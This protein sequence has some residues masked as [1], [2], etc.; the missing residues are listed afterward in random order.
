MSIGEH[1]SGSVGF[2]IKLDTLRSGFVPGQELCWVHARAGVVRSQPEQQPQQ[3]QPPQPSQQSQQTQPSQQEQQSQQPQQPAVVVTMQPLKLSGSDIFYT[4]SDMRT[5]DR[6]RTWQGP[7]EQQSLARRTLEEGIEVAISDFTPGWHQATGKLLGTG[8]TV[9]YRGDAIYRPGRKTA[10]SV[11]DERSRLWNAWRTLELPP[12][13]VTSGAGCTQR[14]DLDNGDILLPVYYAKESGTSPVPYCSTVLRCKF[15]GE[16]LTYVEHGSDVTMDRGRGYYEPSLTRF[17]GRFFLT[18]RADDI[19]AV[20]ASEDGLRFGEPQAWTWDDGS[21]VPTYNTQQHWVTHSDGLFLVY[22]RRAESNGH[23]FRH[24]APLY[25][26]E[27]D[28]ER[29]CLIRETEQIVVPDTGARLGNFGIVDID[30]RETWVIATEW[31]QN[32]GAWGAEMWR[33]LRERYPEEELAPLVDLPGMSGAV[34]KWGADNRTY[35]A[36]ICWDRPNRF[37]AENNDDIGGK[38]R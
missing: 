25:I 38:K 4:L 1:R 16:T 12:S 3:S 29:L 24:R 30:E 31:M 23:V 14:V 8:H 32:G 33:K 20:A 7:R 17:A 22:T 2:R 26:A 21:P 34:S 28:P 35:A 13:F 5:D 27:V 11:Y 6:G 9:A 36:R 37:M 19:G 18:L 10:Y 15:D